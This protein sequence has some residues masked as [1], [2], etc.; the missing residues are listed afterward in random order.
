METKTEDIIVYIFTLIGFIC[1]GTA[2]VLSIYTLSTVDAQ[3][4]IIEN[5]RE[6]IWGCVDRLPK[7][8]IKYVNCPLLFNGSIDYKNCVR[9]VK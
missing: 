9:E 8:E 3:R 1:V 2:I 4:H 6:Q 7:E 5:Q